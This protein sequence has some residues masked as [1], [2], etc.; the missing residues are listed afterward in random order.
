LSVDFSIA[1]EH[2]A[3]GR[4]KLEFVLNETNY[5]R[6]ISRARTFGFLADMRKLHEAGL[7]LGGSLENAV[8]LDDYNV[9]N[10]DGLRFKNEFARHKI[11]DFV[12]DLA[13]MGRPV[14]GR[15]SAHKSGH[16][17]NNRFF[18]KF[19]ADPQCWQL[20]TAPQL[21]KMI[22]SKHNYGKLAAAGKGRALRS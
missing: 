18:R 12:G 15:F 13:L 10:K 19:L 20:V 21:L 3:I 1:F 8:V 14:L 2:P 11:L 17:L 4:Q 22:E 7:A 5:T 6:E 16:D 9:I